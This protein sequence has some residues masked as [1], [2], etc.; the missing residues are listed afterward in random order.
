MICSASSQ[1][2]QKL[3]RPIHSSLSLGRFKQYSVRRRLVDKRNSSELKAHH[4]TEQPKTLMGPLS[5]EQLLSYLQRI[6]RSAK[7]N[8]SLFTR[9]AVTSINIHILSNILASDSRCPSCF[10]EFPLAGSGDLPEASLTT[11]QG[12]HVGQA[13]N[14]IFENLSLHHHKARAQFPEISTDLQASSPPQ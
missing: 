2:P 10:S 12:V 4:K 8:P 5:D 13:L 11:L 7:T 3:Q 6:G 1:L 14:V 9:L